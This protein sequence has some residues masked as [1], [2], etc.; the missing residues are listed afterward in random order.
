MRS[1]Q[2]IQSL[3]AEAERLSKSFHT[4]NNMYMYLVCATAI[5]VA[6]TFIAQWRAKTLAEALEVAN[7][8]VIRAKDEQLKDE[9]AHRD[10]RIAKVKAEADV[11]IAE[12]EADADDK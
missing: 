11:Q 12:V 8:A 1:M 6:L 9:L 2:P 5:F 4:C 3:V 7:N 10:E